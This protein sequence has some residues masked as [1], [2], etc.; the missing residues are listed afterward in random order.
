MLPRTRIIVLVVAVAGGSCTGRGTS[1]ATPHRPDESGG[2][3]LEHDLGRFDVRDGDPGSSAEMHDSGAA[4]VSVRVGSEGQHRLRLEL[5]PHQGQ[6]EDL[7]PGSFE[8]AGTETDYST[9]GLCAY[10][11][12]RLDG[13]AR[14]P[15]A[16]QYYFARSGRV[17]VE[18]AS[19]R[20][21]AEL[22]DV[23][24][25]SGGACAST[26][27]ALTVDLRYSAAAMAVDW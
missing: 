5:Y 23:E 24:L 27:E 26:I 2:C 4:V 14:F 20:L 6:L 22:L 25:A 17:I 12:T 16:D 3:T 7:A 19:D 21:V 8:I 11:E 9:C 1:E 10:V 15:V 18:E 13:A